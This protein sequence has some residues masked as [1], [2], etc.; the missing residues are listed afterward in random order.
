MCNVPRADL[1]GFF[2]DRKDALSKF[3]KSIEPIF[4][5]GSSDIFQFGVAC[6]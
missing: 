5:G 1:D 6:C 2:A 4:F 3:K